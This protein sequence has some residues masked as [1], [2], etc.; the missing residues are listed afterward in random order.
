MDPMMT[1]AAAVGFALLL[2]LSAL[3]LIESRR[4]RRMVEAYFGPPGREGLASTLRYERAPLIVGRKPGVSAAPESGLQSPQFHFQLFD[5]LLEHRD[6]LLPLLDDSLL[7]ADLGTER[8]VLPLQFVNAI[9][10]TVT[11]HNR[12]T[13][14]APWLHASKRTYSSGIVARISQSGW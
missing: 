1:T 4:T 3:A 12:R 13:L 5:A 10:A 7:L 9:V 11:C 6:R 2:L 8:V 14:G